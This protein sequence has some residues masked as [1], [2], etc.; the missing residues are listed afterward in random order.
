[1]ATQVWLFNQ[2]SY[3]GATASK[4]ELGHL[5]GVDT[6]G[7]SLTYASL[8]GTCPRETG[9]SRC[10]QGGRGDLGLRLN[11]GGAKRFPGHRQWNQRAFLFL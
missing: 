2:M 10:E 11:S 7:S 4:V 5:H 9:E 3:S 6:L 8:R 1:M